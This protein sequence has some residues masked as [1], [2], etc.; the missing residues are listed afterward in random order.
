MGRSLKGGLAQAG[1]EIILCCVGRRYEHL[2]GGGRAGVVDR[3]GA[4]TPPPKPVVAHILSANGQP[5]AAQPA[6]GAGNS[7]MTDPVA[8]PS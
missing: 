5:P 6:A 2:H 7:P 1:K 3:S 4:A 8:S